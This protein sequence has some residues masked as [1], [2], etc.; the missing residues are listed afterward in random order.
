[1]RLYICEKPSQAKDISNVIGVV[2]R[3]NG[4]IETK[5]GLVTW[6][7]GHLL[8]DAMPDEYLADDVPVSPK[9]G[10]KVWRMQDLPVIPSSWKKMVRKEAA[11]QYKV[12][13]G[14]VATATEVV[15]ATDADREGEMIAREILDMARYK[16]PIKRLWLSALDDSSVRKAL[17]SLQPGEKTALL[18]DAAL[19]RSRADWLVGM[20]LTRTFTLHGRGKGVEGV[21]SVGRVQTPT[22]ALVVARDREIENFKPSPFHEVFAHIAVQSGSFRARWKAPEDALDEH[23][24]LVNEALAH[25]VKARTEGKAGTISHFITKRV[26]EGAPLPFDLSTLQRECSAKWGYGAQQVLDI[27]QALYETHKATTYP[28]TDCAYLPESQLAEAGQVLAALSKADASL[29]EL[30]KHADKTRKSGAWND[31]KITAH[32]AIIPTASVPNLSSMSAEERNAYD[33]IRKRYL[34]Q[35]FPDAEFDKT[36]VDATIGTDIFSATGRIQ[37]VAG[38]KV[39][40]AVA[41]AEDEYSGE[42]DEGKQSIPVMTQ[43][44]SARAAGVEVESKMTKPPA[45][46][47]E[48]TLIQAMK[49]IGRSVKDPKLKAVLRET[50][51]IGTEATRASILETLFEREFIEKKGKKNIISTAKGRQLIDALPDAV[52]SPVMTALWEQALEEIGEGKRGL[53]AF[54]A[55]QSKFVTKVVESIRGQVVERAPSELTQTEIGTC[56]HCSEQ[57]AKKVFVKSQNK[58]AWICEA[59]NKWSDDQGGTPVMPAPRPQQGGKGKATFSSNKKPAKKK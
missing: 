30:V 22:L 54:V 41:E 6:C 29:S 52:K 19:A 14:L 57:K 12:I 36:D 48:G 9:T 32:H 40:V 18:Y 7:F 8:E 26:K 45:H 27:A 55:D 28:R 53:D 1:M 34:A 5:N 59:C 58:H 3:D 21:L 11:A 35:F 23:G 47:T 16:G 20:N 44:E 51:G 38:W 13:K 10:K 37:K 43:G 46:F 15:I 24:R 4:F 50:S 31:A 17:A 39:V 56:P 49:N 25:E 2:K 42:G 33:L